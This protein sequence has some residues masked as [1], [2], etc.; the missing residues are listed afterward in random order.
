MTL[1]A[2]TGRHNWADYEKC[3][4]AECRYAECRG[5]QAVKNVKDETL[6]FFVLRIYWKVT[7]FHSLLTH[8]PGPN[9]LKLF[10]AVIY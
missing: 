1:Y 10:T 6:S 4:Y 5:A 7:S 3:R 9:V 2:Y 8:R